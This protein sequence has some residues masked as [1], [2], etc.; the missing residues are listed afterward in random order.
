[1]LNQDFGEDGNKKEKS[2]CLWNTSDIARFFNINVNIWS[3]FRDNYLQ[4]FVEKH[5]KSSKKFDRYALELS[6]DFLRF[7]ELV[8]TNNAW[9]SHE[10]VDL[11][12]R[13]RVLVQAIHRQVLNYRTTSDY[14]ATL[15][16]PK[17]Q[18]TLPRRAQT[19]DVKV[20][21][22]SMSQ[23]GTTI[24]A[25]NDE[26]IVLE[27]DG[28]SF[29]YLQPSISDENLHIRITRQSFSPQLSYQT[30]VR[31]LQRDSDN[32]EKIFKYLNYKK[33]Q[34]CATLYLGFD[35]KTELLAVDYGSK[36]N[37]EWLFLQDDYSL[38]STIETWRLKHPEVGIVDVLVVER[39][40]FIPYRSPSAVIAGF[41]DEE[42]P[43][44]SDED[45]DEN[46]NS[47]EDEDEEK[48]DV[49]EDDKEMKDEN[50]D[51]E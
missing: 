42:M 44:D 33:L 31:A 14:R 17:P 48:S 3:G 20:E 2:L 37:P 12:R 46:E 27:D 23:H 43:D 38:R 10:G 49:D 39:P 19:A 29:D 24:S 40:G 5:V 32:I 22:K 41:V 6:P 34:D 11:E 30:A 51:E 18:T 16:K 35:I 26:N 47:D 28:Q 25:S 1:M 4:P 15:V 13:R 9:A 7:E 50:D 8:L 21:S 45:E 36:M